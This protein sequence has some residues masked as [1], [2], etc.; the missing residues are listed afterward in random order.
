MIRREISGA[1]DLTVKTATFCFSEQIAEA[2]ELPMSRSDVILFLR[3]I[4]PKQSLSF[5]KPK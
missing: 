1:N 2:R 3:D 5:L 4:G